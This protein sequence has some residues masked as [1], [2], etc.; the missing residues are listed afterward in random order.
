MQ[1][2]RDDVKISDLW[3]AIKEY[4]QDNDANNSDLIYFNFEENKY[5]R[6]YFK[7]E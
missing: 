6:I 2:I 3:E 4:I 1:E 5:E 7:Y